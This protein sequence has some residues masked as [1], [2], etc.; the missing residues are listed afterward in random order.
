MKSRLCV[1][2]CVL[3]F[4]AFA[5]VLIAN[6]P[7]FITNNAG[8][9]TISW[10]VTGGNWGLEGSPV[11]P[12]AA[13]WTGVVPMFDQTNGVIRRIKVASVDTN[14]FFRL[15]RLDAGVPGLTGRWQLDEGTGQVAYD[16]GGAG[17]TLFLSGVNWTSG[18]TGTGAL[19]FNGNGGAAGSHCWV[20][21]SNHQILPAPEQPFSVSFWFNPDV[22]TPGWRGL[23]G[24][25]ADGS[26]GWH[27][28]LLT[29]GPGTNYLKFAGSG[30]QP[31]L[32]VTGRMLLLPRK[33]YHLTVTHDGSVGSI[34][35]DSA[36]LAIGTG[37]VPAHQGPIYF[38]GGVGGYNSLLGRI[39]DIRT[40][41]NC[42]SDE[43][44]ALVGHWRF[45]EGLG[46]F[47]SDSSRSEHHGALADSSGW[48]EGREG[49]GVDL[50]V[51]HVQIPNEDLTVM[52]ATGK[53][54]SISFWLRPTALEAGR[55]GLMS[56]GVEAVNGW[57]LALVR[58]QFGWSFLHFDS[59]RFGGTLDL[60]VPIQLATAVWSKVEVTFNGGIAT[61]YCNGRK[62]GA[63][64]GAI[65][66]SRARMV[67]GQVPGLTTFPAVID[68][69]KVY[70]RERSESEIGPV[71]PVMWETVLMNSA[72][73][74]PLRGSGP[75]G[76]VLVYAID[77][78]ITPTNGT[79]SI[80]PGSA[81][82]TYVAGSRKGPDAF[83]YT[84]SDGEFTS[85]PSIVTVSVVEPH[86]LSPTGGSEVPLDGR[87]P[88]RAWRADTPKA[89]DAIWKTNNY[90]DCFF[91]SPGE[92]ETKGWKYGERSSANPGCKHIGSGST[93]SDK[94]VIRLVDIWEPW[95]EETIFSPYYGGQPV[96]GF[97]LDGMVLDCNADNVPKYVSGIPVSIR[98]PLAPPGTV[99][100]NLTLRW[101]KSPVPGVVPP[102]LTGRAANFSV[103]ALYSG[104]NSFVTNWTPS[105]ATS[106]VS[107]I[108]LGVPAD[109]LL[110]QLERRAARVDLYGLSEVEISGAS[111]SLPVALVPG[112]GESRLDPKYSIVLA[113]DD[114]KQTA[115]ASGPEGQ[116]QIEVPLEPGTAIT[117]L[118]FRWNCRFVPD[119]GRLGPA[120]AYL[121]RARDEASGLYVEVP[122]TRRDRDASG[123]ET[124]TLGGP[125]S[126][127]PVVT[128]RLV[129]VLTERE[130]LVNH[131]SL[132]EVT[133]RNGPVSVRPRIPAALN[134]SLL[135]S[136]SILR[137]FDGDN[138][139]EWASDTQGMVGAVTVSGNNLK[140]TNLRIVGFG[141]K[142]GREG[143][144]MFLMPDPNGAARVGNVLVE[145]CVFSDPATN[146]TDGMTAVALIGSPRVQLT[147]A[148]IRR[149]SM[150]GLKPRFGYS[151]ATMAMHV[152]NCLVID[153]EV[154]VYHE[155]DPS[156]VDSVGATVVRS[157]QFVRVDFGVYVSTEASAVFD[158]IVC[159]DNEIVLSDYPGWGFGICDTCAIGPSGTTTNVVVLNNVIRYLGWEPRP[160]ATGGGLYSSDIQ[161][162]VFGNNLV[163]LGG[164][165]SAE[166]RGY[167]FGFIP[168]PPGDC[169]NLAPYPPPP[170]T[171]PPSL[172]VLPPGYRRAWFENR[173]LS[174]LLLPI[175]VWTNNAHGLA[176]QQQWAD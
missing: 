79:V 142:T 89:L 144:P 173:D 110:I 135:G 92:Y 82:V 10:P 54:F 171:S 86:W 172:D 168:P 150:L 36:R 50:A 106:Q 22:L 39:D 53:P 117:H 108:N 149:C 87:S 132:R 120:S 91:Y 127:S 115:W 73:N 176:S 29:T 107:V 55:F 44:I 123:F 20:S 49:A 124:A 8:E 38:G 103:T 118:D 85:A 147:N 139:S 72:T 159:M 141:T 164:V 155:P 63:G 116:V 130:A 27:V 145:D 133:L 42:L 37:A 166:V 158:S 56:C 26:N 125:G 175:T 93:G 40:F 160:L 102:S 128:D 61:L 5:R 66:A 23:A 94:T 143:F 2:G 121:I 105:M 15:R 140:F 45:N 12:P 32:S 64:S 126:V 169:D 9:I 167:P 43:A 46:G 13:N 153:C 77:P 83:T 122:F 88:A 99:V 11:L 152:E 41:T 109:E 90:Y 113:F 80:Q 111:A 129:I 148:I 69:L 28:A 18:R 76:R 3:W 48:T 138:A 21:N 60:N 59:T 162:A 16:G 24:T 114:D 4:G 100:S 51:G 19:Q 146:N 81:V 71:A 170:P 151:H 101:G 74:F 84:L 104:T 68:E 137:A 97:E 70:G 58:D 136:F 30:L 6:Q 134:S 33:W 112:A 47:V 96:D 7:L 52:P 131:F 157:N 34:Y 31:S 75:S 154:A 98:I 119:L 67:V 17:G 161:H 78:T 163:V 156:L 35:L 14:R 95:I 1:A 174:G 65:R 25:D 165:R 62:I 57:Q